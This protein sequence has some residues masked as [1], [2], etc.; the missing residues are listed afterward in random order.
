MSATGLHTEWIVEG[1]LELPDDAI[2]ALARLLLSVAEV[3]EDDQRLDPGPTAHERA[4][5]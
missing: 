5:A 1:G 4:S 3:D 2:E